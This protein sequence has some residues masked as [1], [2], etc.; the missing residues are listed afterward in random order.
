MPLSTSNQASLFNPHRW[1]ICKAADRFRVLSLLEYGSG[2]RD[3]ARENYCF[4]F[5]D[6]GGGGGREGDREEG[7]G[8]ENVPIVFHDTK[9]IRY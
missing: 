4:L 9:Q 3:T 1:R 5:F 6:A 8:K 7:V 2:Y